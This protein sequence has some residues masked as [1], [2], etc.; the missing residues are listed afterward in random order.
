M[1]PS[2]IYNPNPKAVPAT[3]LQIGNEIITNNELKKFFKDIPKRLDL[4]ENADDVSKELDVAALVQTVDDH[5]DR[6]LTLEST[7]SIHSDDIIEIYQSLGDRD[8]VFF[9]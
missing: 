2:E 9:W 6:I 8:S 3:Q 5:D 7:T 4:I 1:F